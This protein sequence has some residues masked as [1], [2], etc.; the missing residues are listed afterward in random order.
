METNLEA[1]VEA[2]RHLLD[3][4]VDNGMAEVE[5]IPHLDAIYDWLTALGYGRVHEENLQP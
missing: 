5:D 2:I 4:Y 3:V 1:P